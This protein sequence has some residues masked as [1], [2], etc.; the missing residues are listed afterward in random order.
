[1][2]ALRHTD[3][4]AKRVEGLTV[5]SVGNLAVGG[6]G[7]TPVVAWIAATLRDASAAPAILVGGHGRD[8]ALLHSRR[9]PDVPVITNRDRTEGAR[10]ALA[11][12]A[13][14]AILDDGFQ[15]RTLR[16]D[17]DVVLLAAEDS[18]P[19]SVLPRGPYRERPGALRR[20]DVVLVTRRGVSV[21]ESRR[22][23]EGVEA[24]HTGL[25][26]GGLHLAASGWTDLDG[27]STAP[28]EGD[29]LAACAIAR[30]AAFQTV[31]ARGVTGSVELVAFADH[32]EYTPADI[33]RIAKRAS[34]R[35]IV[36]TE[37]DAVKFRA[38][39]GTSSEALVLAE[40]VRWDWG[41][42]AFVARLRAAT[43][44]GTDT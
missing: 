3:G 7:K 39:A 38:L 36:I 10:E 31:V 1:V 43:A 5:I 13:G 34:G 14:V 2:I 40:E 15:H 32:H 44:L 23:A 4:R 35:S 9:L 26:V 29:V 27:N 37:K 22:L 17:L 8:E 41:E 6:T 24:R 33:G 12:G 25:V 19:G 21:E 20:A 42:E 16:R 18:F 30:P 28:P 11:R